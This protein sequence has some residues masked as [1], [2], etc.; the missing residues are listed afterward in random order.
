RLGADVIH[1]VP[2][3]RGDA[4]DDV[5]RWSDAETE[6]VDERIAGIARLEP[7]LAANS[8]NTDAVAVA[9]DA[10]DHAFEHAPCARGVER[11]ETQRVQQRY[12]TRAHGEDIADDYADAGSGAL[13]RLDKRGM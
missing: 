13:I 9:R 10:G 11:S 3:A 12:R 7:D 1:R 5:G 4:F 6:H 2:G 8:R